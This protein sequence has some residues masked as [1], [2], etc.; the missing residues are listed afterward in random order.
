MEDVKFTTEYA[1]AASSPSNQA[2]QV[3]FQHSALF[4][5]AQSTLRAA[6]KKGFLT[7]VPGL[8]VEALSKHPPPSQRRKLKDI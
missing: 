1:N 6:V 2:E 4:S 7:T 3:A 5:P 8:T